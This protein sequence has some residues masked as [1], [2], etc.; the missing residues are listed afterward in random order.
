MDRATH[1]GAPTMAA[2]VNIGMF[3]LGNA[4]GAWVGGATIAAG[5]G[6]VSPNWAGAILSF[7][8]LGLAFLAWQSA[9]RE[10]ILSSET[11]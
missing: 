10:Y 2:S 1:A 8:A 9:R 7:I 6:L 3:N 4:L 11:G 5:L